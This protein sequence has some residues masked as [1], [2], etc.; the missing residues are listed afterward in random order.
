MTRHSQRPRKVDLAR[1]FPQDLAPQFFAEIT[2][3]GKVL[4]YKL[5]ERHRDCF[6]T[7]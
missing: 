3:S 1:G 7:A 2:T 6:L 4:K 5:R